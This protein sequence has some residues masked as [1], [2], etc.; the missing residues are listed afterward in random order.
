MR[1]GLM[2]IIFVIFLVSSVSAAQ[3]DNGNLQVS[4]NGRYLEHENGEA[5]FWFGDTAWAIFHRLNLNEAEIYFSD[6]ESKG[7]TVIQ[8]TILGPGKIQGLD[9]AHNIANG[10]EPLINMDPTTPNEAFFQHVDAIIDKA[11][12][13]NIYVAL[14]PIFGEYVC[15]DTTPDGWGDGPVIFN[16]TNA[17][18]YGEWLGNRYK[19]KENIIWVNGGDRNGDCNGDESMSIFRAIANGI[20]SE[21]SNH[22]ITYH[23]SF[24][25]SYLWFHDDAWLDFDMIQIYDQPERT[26]EFITYGYEMS[27]IKP[28]INA[29]PSYYGYG[30]E[31]ERTYRSQPYWTILSGGPGF[32]YGQ[33]YVW[34]YEKTTDGNDLS[35]MNS[36]DEDEDWFNYLDTSGTIWT[37][38][39]KDL[40]SSMEWEKLVPDQS[41]FLTSTGTGL[42]LK[43]AAKMSDGKKIIAYFPEGG[44]ATISL[45]PISDSTI[46]VRWFNPKNGVYSTPT[47]YSKTSSR[48][49][50]APS[51]GEDNDWVLLINSVAESGCGDGTC[52]TG[53]CDTCAQDCSFSDCCDDGTCN[54]G[55]TYS[56][57]PSDCPAPSTEPIAYWKF[58]ENGG[59]TAFDSVGDNDGN[60]INGTGW[61]TGISG[62]AV[63]FDGSNDYVDTIS[64]ATDLF[65]N[66]FTISA[67]INSGDYEANAGFWAAD[68][69]GDN[70][71]YLRHDDTN[72]DGDIKLGLS[73][74]NPN[75]DNVY[76]TGEWMHYVVVLDGTTGYLYVNGVLLDSQ[77]GL[78]VSIPSTP[79]TFGHNGV[80]YFNG[81]IDEVKIYNRALS[82][83]EITALF[84]EFNSL[85]SSGADTNGDSAVSISELINYIS[86]WKSGEV[87][88]SELINGISE[89]KSGCA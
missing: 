77:S 67:W 61:T 30:S 39:W 53:E 19:D 84:N 81:L 74:W 71:L 21:D 28:V 13:H 65:T 38:H 12:E 87:S 8:A 79:F 2:L 34:Y 57:C 82:A 48:E 63:S 59:T 47:T 89:W 86:Q 6:R 9:P 23:P 40:F 43:V 72:N 64:A 44:S 32:N 50:T 60:L 7:F 51:S 16:P 3:W 52:D 78:I 35:T 58:D 5:F 15:D 85:C 14:L 33:K 22:V 73:D 37:V 76:D 75:Y 1:K 56:T 17:Q 41:L 88:I 46:S 25:G 31:T 66:D 54:N 70:R 27:P 49:F 62:S 20:K 42:Q 45:T 4:S 55:E 26:N 24:R 36:G 18:T 29:E 69:S 10:E 11:A 80:T 83:S 68:T